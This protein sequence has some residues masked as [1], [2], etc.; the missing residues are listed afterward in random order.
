MRLQKDCRR[1]GVRD[2]VADKVIDMKTKEELS[3]GL[4]LVKRVLDG[5][6]QS[7]FSVTM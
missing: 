6:R 3:A 7:S 2:G 5:E 4:Q 1:Y